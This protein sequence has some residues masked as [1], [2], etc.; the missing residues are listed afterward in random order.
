MRNIRFTMEGEKQTEER[1]RRRREIVR[2]SIDEI[3]EMTAVAHVVF[4]WCGELGSVSEASVLLFVRMGQLLEAAISDVWS[5]WRT[6]PRVCSDSRAFLQSFED[7]LAAGLQ[8]RPVVLPLWDTSHT[9]WHPYAVT[10]KTVHEGEDKTQNLN[11]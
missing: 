3:R 2:S 8:I 7:P 10:R 1:E 4:T 6:L 11:S 5:Q 9:L